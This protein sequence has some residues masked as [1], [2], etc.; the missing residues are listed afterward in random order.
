MQARR[1][2]PNIILHCADSVSRKKLGLLPS[3][4][5]VRGEGG[6]TIGRMK[7]GRCGRLRERAVNPAPRSSSTARCRSV[8]QESFQPLSTRGK[9]SKHSHVVHKAGSPPAGLSL[10]PD[11]A[12][13]DHRH[14]GQRRRLEDDTKMNTSCMQPMRRWTDASPLAKSPR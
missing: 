2:F 5:E 6:L 14:L 12:R 13:P 8:R 9:A 3:S 7:G 1:Q 4:M 10:W 11:I